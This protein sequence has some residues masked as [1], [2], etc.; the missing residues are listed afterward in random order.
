M[1]QEKALELMKK[2]SYKLSIS[3]YSSDK[4]GKEF[5]NLIEDTYKIHNYRKENFI[6]SRIYC[7]IKEIIDRVFAL[8]CLIL[9]PLMLFICLLIKVNMGGNIFSFK[10]TRAIWENI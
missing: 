8:I 10:E 2:N 5:I 7:L 1:F 3:K 6:F 9:S 4:V